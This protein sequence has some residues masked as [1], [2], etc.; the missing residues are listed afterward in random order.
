VAF[1]YYI[2]LAI[3]P[4]RVLQIN[5]NKE[6]FMKKKVL[7]SLVLLAIIG[8]SAVFAQAP[9]LDKLKLTVGVTYV[10]AAAAN[11]QIKGE[12]VIPDTHEGKPV[13]DVGVFKD[14]TGI[15][16][17]VIPTSVTNFINDAFKRCTNL[18]SV[19]FGGSNINNASFAFDGDLGA[20]F[21]AGGAG[22]YTRQAGGT[23]WTKQGGYTLNGTYT[24]SDGT[25][26]T[27]TDNGQNV[28]ITGN[29]PNNGGRINETL[30]R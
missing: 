8:T 5:P 22:T 28:I 7:M 23:V 12:V 27:I 18:T 21:K 2:H 3:N 10:T 19:T 11:N 17:V 6:F 16:S 25:Q 30:R 29:Y 9:T 20:K 1:Y 24:R 26:I 15:T 14:I 4:K 13:K